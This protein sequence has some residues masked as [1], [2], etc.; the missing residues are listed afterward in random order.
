M[1]KITLD[2]GVASD[3]QKRNALTWAVAFMLLGIA[4]LLNLLW[5]Y[6]IDDNY[7]RLIVDNLSVFCVNLAL[8]TKILHTEYTINRYEFYKGYYFTIATA[9]LMFFTTIVTPEAVRTIGFYQNI[10]LIL[11]TV[12]GSIFPLIF[13]YLAIKLK[14]KER[15]LAIRMLAGAFLFMMGLLFQPHNIE[16]FLIAYKWPE[17]DSWLLIFLFL[18]PILIIIATFETYRSYSKVL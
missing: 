18:C 4:N 7:M 16:P 11:L 3:L 2:K 10:Y 5:R 8:F 12:G 1:Y 15:Q 9:A 13:L 6:T 17:I 14:G